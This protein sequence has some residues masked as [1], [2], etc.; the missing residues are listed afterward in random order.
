MNPFPLSLF[1]SYFFPT[2][3]TARECK[4]RIGEIER[5][6]VHLSDVPV[7]LFVELEVM[8]GSSGTNGKPEN[9]R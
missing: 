7:L 4:I 2:S 8:D 6:R 1:T 3:L 5:V 9:R